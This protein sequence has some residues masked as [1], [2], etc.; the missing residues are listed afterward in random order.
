MAAEQDAQPAYF[1]GTPAQFQADADVVLQL[2]SGEHLPAHSQLLASTS[3]VL[4]DMLKVAASQVP[5]GGEIVLQLLGW[6]SSTEAVDV[7][8]AR[9]Q[10]Q[11]V[12]MMCQSCGARCAKCYPSRKVECL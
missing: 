6:D 7:L 9:V 10:Q 11:A 5:A 12:R 2:R 3:P 4:C 8:K 1:A